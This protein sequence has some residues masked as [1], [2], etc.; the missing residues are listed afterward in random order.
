MMMNSAQHRGWFSRVRP[1][2]AAA[3]LAFA[4]VG[5]QWAQAQTFK[6]VHTFHSGK[7]PIAPSGQLILDAQGNL[8]G[9]AGGGT[10]ICEYNTA[11]G[12][13]FKMAKTGKL[14]WVYSFKGVDGKGP[15]G[16]GPIG[17]LLR[18]SAGNLFG[19][20]LYGGKTIGRNGA[21]SI[22]CGVVFKLD[23]TGM[24]ETVLHKFIGIPQNGGFNPEALLIQDSAGNLYGTTLWG[25]YGNNGVVF[26]ANQAGKE[27]TLYTFKGGADGGTDPAG[28]IWGSA[29]NLYGTAGYGLYNWGVLFEVNATTGEETV[30]YNFLGSSYGSGVFSLLVADAAGNLY[31]TTSQGGN[32]GCT[33][34]AGCGVLYELSPQAGGSWAETVLY[35]FCPQEGC[36]D[37]QEPLFGHNAL[38]GRKRFQL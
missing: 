6:V 21:C 26:K 33:Y 34:G 22:G 20:T 30:L 32:S 2:T 24:K 9:V 10:G 3:V 17:G 23:K 13:V 25:G 28:V 16:E 1:Q 7:G 12:T 14:V 38:R 8:Y 35:T 5:G 15:Y 29:G 31:G 36:P 4:M 18:D 19:V 27:T 37:G 11:C